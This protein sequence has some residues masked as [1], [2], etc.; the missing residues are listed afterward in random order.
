MTRLTK[1]ETNDAGFSLT[2]ML[3]VLT[4]TSLLM[5]FLFSG[6]FWG[7][8]ALEKSNDFKDLE[9]IVALQSRLDD[10]ISQAR[11]NY[12]INPQGKRVSTFEGFADH[13]NITSIPIAK[14]LNI[15]TYR[16]QIIQSEPFEGSDLIINTAL[17]FERNAKDG[18]DPFANAQT[19]TLLKEI[20]TVRFSYFGQTDQDS[21]P[22]WHAEWNLHSHMPELVKIEI[23][24]EDK[25][26]WPELIIDVQLARSP[27]RKVLP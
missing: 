18:D 4:I 3:V 16:T 7:T 22:E 24:F 17:Y 8:K 5:S 19:Y 14:S 23:E 20:K 10:V 9:R 27:F 2:E 15:G 6:I 12:E 25:R 21:E 13:L 26:I 11:L 1:Y